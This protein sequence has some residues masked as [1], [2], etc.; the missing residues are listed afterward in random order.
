MTHGSGLSMKKSGCAIIVLFV[1]VC[2]S[3]FLNLLFV[4][5]WAG[6]GSRAG[7]SSRVLHER[8]YEEVMVKEGDASAGKIVVIPL[9]GVIAHGAEGSLG[10]NMVEDFKAA[11]EQ[12]RRDENVKAVVIAVDSPGGEITASDVLYHSLKEFTRHKPSVIYF[13]SLGASGAYYTA[14]GASYI[15]CNDTTFTGSIGV[16]ISTLNYREL[17]GKVGLQSVVF[18]S[19]AFKDMLNGARELTPEEI[20]YIQGLVMQSYDR[21]VGI[22]AKARKLDEQALRN[23]VADG[24]ILSGTDAYEAK[25]VDQLGYVENAHAKAAELG[26]APGAQ[27]VRYKRVVTFAH[28]LRMFSESRSKAPEIKIGGLESLNRLEPGRVYLLPPF[29]AP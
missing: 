23:G 16:I 5:A 6:K 12:A 10:D 20:A 24:R 14:C 7:V 25:L 26:R 4:A 2:A 19:G 13:N 1:A 18:K 21:F 11:L 29:Y 9:E 17:F 28:F 8:D 15:M 3:M 22:V 27:V